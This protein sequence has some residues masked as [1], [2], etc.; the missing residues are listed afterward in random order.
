MTGP[1]RRRARTGVAPDSTAGTARRQRPIAFW[2]HQLLEYLLAVGLVVL[3][4]HIGRSELL[5]T[6]GVIFG[7]LAL[8]ARGPL[9]IVRVCGP[10]LHA[11][12]DI[13]A[14]GFIAVAPLVRPLRP[15]AVGIVVVE[16][17]AL[18]WVRL[19]TLTRYSVGRGGR[20]PARAAVAPTLAPSPLDP[21]A[22]PS[23]APDEPPSGRA[24]SAIRGLGRMTAEAKSRLPEVQ[25]T[26]DTHARRIGGHTRRLQRAWRRARP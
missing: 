24:L 14:A 7:V 3:S 11:V 22:R 6:G 23:R 12:L 13:A 9:G 4:V 25:P 10:R 18:A 21:G 16:L 15:G 17:S 2:L 1:A 20:S 26:L 8:T 5:L 19:A